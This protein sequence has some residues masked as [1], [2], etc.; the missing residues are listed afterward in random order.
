MERVIAT[1]KA[2]EEA[3]APAAEPKKPEAAAAAAEDGKPKPKEK[4]RRSGDIAAL[5]EREWKVTQAQ[6]AADELAG[7]YRPLEEALGKRD[8]VAVLNHLAD[9]HG[10][11]FADFVAVLD[12]KEP[13]KK[14]PEQIA[15]ET[16]DAKLKERDAAA[17]K[18]REAAEAKALDERVTAIRTRLDT[19]AEEGGE[20]WELT[21]VAGRGSEAWD[22]VE[23]WHAETG[24]KL[25]LEE[26]LDLVEKKLREKRDARR[27][28][29]DAVKPGAGAKPRNEAGTDR[30]DGRAGSPSFN[31]RSTSGMPAAVGAQDVD[32]ATLPDHEAIEVAARRAGLRL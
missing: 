32:I 17:A 2:R 13:P 7:K 6:R 1:A 23:K 11:T 3:A 27:P 25:P 15:A 8:L 10:V 12:G 24:Q 21:A 5:A 20:R 31:N 26:A 4:P 28:K 29:Q 14:P 18:E 19:M 16:V 30:T 9:K 22:L